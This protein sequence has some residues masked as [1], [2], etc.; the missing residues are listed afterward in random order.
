M[1]VKITKIMVTQQDIEAMLRKFVVSEFGITA[2]EIGHTT[3]TL[4]D[5]GTV[6]AEVILESE[7]RGGTSL[8]EPVSDE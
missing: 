1:A 2:D 6:L 4:N 7:H 3:F 8:T 5:S